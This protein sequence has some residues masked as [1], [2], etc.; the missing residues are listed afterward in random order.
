MAKKSDVIGATGIIRYG[1]RSRVE[2]EWHP[3]LRGRLAARVYRE[4]GDNDATV[5]GSFNIIKATIRQVP[6]HAQEANGSDEAK[7]WAERL[8]NFIEDMDLT[9][10]D[11]T[12]DVMSK[13]QY[14][15]AAFEKVHKRRADGL[16][17]WRG[18]FMRSQESLYNWEWGQE[19]EVKGMWQLVQSL[20]GKPVFIPM[21]KLL[22]FKTEYNRGSPEGR[23]LLRNIYRT[24]FFLKRLQELEAIGIERD[25]GGIPIVEVPLSLFEAAQNPTPANAGKRA[26]LQEF[27]KLV[28]QL[29]RN[30]RE[31]VVFPAETGPDGKPT[32]YRLRLMSTGGTRAINVGESIRRLQ[33]EIGINFSTTFQQ[34]GVETQGSMALSSDMTSMFAQ[35]LGAVISSMKE[36]FNRFAVKEIME[37]NG[38]PK[39]LWPRWVPGDI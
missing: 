38:A 5:G 19:D 29:R 10:T 30:D 8:T 15:W 13:L 24:W 32:G 27:E 12:S 16:I 22:I 25:L 31:G 14:G 33:K 36:V 26:Q 35:S 23:S 2:D 3:N 11:F 9:W 39:E 21:E 37:L 20:Q 17:G 34:L 18:F 28:Q 7:L 1:N 6:W 4:I